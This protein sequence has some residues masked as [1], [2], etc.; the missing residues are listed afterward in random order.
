MAT[1]TKNQKLD[2]GKWFK[3]GGDVG[4]SPEKNKYIIEK[5]IKKHEANIARKIK[6]Y[7]EQVRERADAVATYLKSVANGKEKS[8]D[9]YFGRRELARLRGQ[10]IIQKLQGNVTLLDDKGNDT[11]KIIKN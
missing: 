2:Y 4:F 3:E 7:E 8:V 1:L 5:T 9:A 11:L 6:S 10:Q